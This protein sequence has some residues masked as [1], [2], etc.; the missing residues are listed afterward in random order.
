M[1]RDADNYTIYYS[2]SFIPETIDNIITSLYNYT[3]EFD[4]PTYKHIISGKGTGVYYFRV[5]SF[6]E[7]GNSTSE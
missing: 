1:V 5:V 6:N 4:W 2:T 7:Y 3:P